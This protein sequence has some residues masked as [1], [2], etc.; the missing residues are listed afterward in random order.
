MSTQQTVISYL[1]SELDA[2]G[3][4]RT[5]VTASDETAYDQATS[6]W[7]AL[8]PAARA[9]VGKI[10]THGYQYGGGRRDLLY[11]AANNAG[12]VLWN[13]EY[14]EGDAT[15][16]SLASNLNLDFT[17]LHPTAWVDRQAL[18]GWRAGA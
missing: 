8:S 15:G 2:R 9:S 10:N 6:T 18:D 12:K 7:N 5:M 4:T 11:A 1:R 14:G 16:L 13:S 17:W 3:L